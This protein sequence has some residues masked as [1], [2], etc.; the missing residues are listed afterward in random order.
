MGKSGGQTQPRARS[1]RKRL[2]RRSSSEWKEIAASR[3]P[4]RSSSHASGRALSSDSSSSFTAIRTA[5]NTRLAGCPPPKLRRTAA[6]SAASTAATSSAVVSIGARSRRRTI[7]WAIRRGGGLLAVAAEELRQAA[8]LPAVH[9]LTRV[10]VL[11]GIHPHVERRVVG[12]GEA[13]LARVHLHG[14]DAQVQVHEVGLRALLGQESQAVG[15]VHAQEAGV[16][17]WPRRRAPGS[18]PP[19]PG[20]GRCTRACRR[21]RAVRPPGARDRPRRRCSPQRS[22]RRRG[23]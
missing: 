8:L 14:R 23:R 12:V 4:S 21:A 5:W 11:A 2:T 22:R 18:V 10:H 13:A 17:T 6:G 3:P 20:H 16:D 1:T 7:S 19:P 9:D 15:V